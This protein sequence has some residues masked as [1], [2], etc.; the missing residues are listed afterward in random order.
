MKNKLMVL[1][2][3]VLIKH[4]IKAQIPSNCAPYSSSTKTEN[5]CQNGN[6]VSTDPKN[7]INDD[8]P[9][10]KNDFEWRVKHLKGAVAPNEFY[11]AYDENGVV[12]G[13]HNP[14]NDPDNSEYRYL[15]ANHNSNYYP[16]DG[17]EML[18][19]DFGALSNFKTG[20]TVNDIDQPGMNT[21]TGGKKLPYMILYNKYSGTFRF[22]GALLGQNQDYSTIKI[23]LRI[24]EKSPNNSQD[25]TKNTYQP[26]L[27]STNL[28]S[29]QGESIQPLDQETD[30]NVMVV[31]ATAT[32]SESKFFWFDIPV[33]FDPCLCSIRSQLDI[34]FSFVKTAD[35]IL[36]EVDN[37]VKTEKR[38]DNTDFGVKVI[39][40]V[41]AVGVAT[42]TAISTG[43]AV[44]NIKAYADL[45]NL[46][47]TNPFV[48]LNQNDKDNLSLL[49]NYLNCGSQFSKVIQNNYGKTS[50][51]DSIQ[52]GKAAIEIVEG[53][54]TFLTSLSNNCG[55]A[56]NGAA[57]ISG[58]MQFSGTFTET[59]KIS[60]TEINLAVPGSNWSDI[61]MQ[62]NNYVDDKGKTVPVY[63]SYNERLGVFAM[64]ETPH[65][66]MVAATEEKSYESG[67]VGYDK[68][69]VS[70]KLK[71]DIAYA[72]NPLI[73]V[74]EN[75]TL[76]SCRYIGIDP[77]DLNL[78][79]TD[80]SGFYLERVASTCSGKWEMVGMKPLNATIN[81]NVKNQLYSPFVPLDQFKDLKIVF[82]LDHKN[83][84]NDDGTN[85]RYVNPSLINKFIYVQFKITMTSKNIGKNGKNISAVYYF[86]Y[87]IQLNV[88]FIR[89]PR[90]IN[91]G[92]QLSSPTDFHDCEQFVSYIQKHYFPSIQSNFKLDIKNILQEN[93]DFN[94]DVVF[95]NTEDVIYDGFVTISAK[96]ST[97]PGK[98]VKI[99]STIGFELESGA[100]ISPDIELVVGLP[101]MKS[102]QKAQSYSQISDFCSS[103]KYKAQ[104]FSQDAVK[105]EADFYNAQD[106]LAK[107][108]EASQQLALLLKIYPNPTSSNFNVSVYNH[109]GQDY[110][111]TLMDM[112][113]KVIMTQFCN[114][115][116]RSQY[117]ETNGLAA[118]VYFV[119]VSCG[120]AQKIE[121]IIVASSY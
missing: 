55:A 54:T 33:A 84:S 94:S 56:E 104:I 67:L 107:D 24:P 37:A 42:A 92:L 95:Q 74:D 81:Y 97:L 83:P 87:P 48:T 53:H 19:V 102:P 15:A 63:P 108:Y 35:I 43:G 119:K 80:Q 78:K 39:S 27:K 22:F 62:I 64:L 14:F 88:R 112:T 18:K 20:Y 98:K 72:F 113:G 117:I 105:R 121:K 6:G 12:K 47:K 34:N 77:K 26:D 100:D 109:K 96:L 61:N 115:L 71:D 99:Y 65:V 3:L 38:P 79:F 86:T 11:I 41:I 60:H 36:N 25:L 110:S 93:K 118:G 45:V 111:I 40:R 103:N 50:S 116:Q 90:M 13:L 46:I 106:K 7:L 23:E 89:A 69:L 66:E 76:I 44:V 91:Q 9:D 5:A 75:K 31:F 59:S 70:L 73:N 101:L 4:E 1:L 57:A 2:V 51:K 58:A 30:E 52:K 85:N 17:W 32:N 28:L 10:L 82:Y 68:L 120:D 29:I 114:G 49:E 16:E 8:C 21:I